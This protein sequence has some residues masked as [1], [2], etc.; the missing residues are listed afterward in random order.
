MRIEEARKAPGLD[1]SAKGV[2]T[3]EK[4]PKDK[5][6]ATQ[7]PEAGNVSNQQRKY[8]ASLAQMASF[9]KAH[10]AFFVFLSLAPGPVPS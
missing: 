2:S 10:T 8:T 1:K 6:L 4:R 9:L 7:L 3:G 5:I